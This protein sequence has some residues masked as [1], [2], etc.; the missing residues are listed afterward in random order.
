MV[1][2]WLWQPDVVAPPPGSPV[3]IPPAVIG[4]LD[5]LAGQVGGDRSDRV[6]R[7]VERLFSDALFRLSDGTV[8]AL[9]GDIPAMWLRDSTWQM[10]PLL[11]VAADDDETARL[12]ADVSRR[13]TRCVP[14]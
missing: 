9:S 1:P 7:A 6:R 11:A 14:R 3:A 8:F 10:R 2:R 5:G 4:L 13:Q 12:I